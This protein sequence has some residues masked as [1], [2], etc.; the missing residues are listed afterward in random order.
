[1]IILCL[2]FSPKSLDCAV[3]KSPNVKTPDFDLISDLALTHDLKYCFV[4]ILF[5]TDASHRD[6]FVVSVTM[7]VVCNLVLLCQV[8]CL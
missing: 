5:P 2:S 3:P 7:F 8:L 1:M 4:W 6:I